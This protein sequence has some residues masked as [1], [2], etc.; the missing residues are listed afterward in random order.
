VPAADG[1]D[2]RTRQLEASGSSEGRLSH[3]ELAKDEHAKLAD[4]PPTAADL[5]EDAADPAEDVLDRAGDDQAGEAER[6]EPRPKGNVNLERQVREAE[7]E[8]VRQPVAL[9]ATR[10]RRLV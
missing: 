8:Q 3:H 2:G 6:D 4:A 7:R 9:R 1:Y 10:R 5:A